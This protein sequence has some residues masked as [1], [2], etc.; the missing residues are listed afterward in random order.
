MRVFI[1]SVEKNKKKKRTDAF[2]FVD[3]FL[4]SPSTMQAKKQDEDQAKLT[5]TKAKAKIALNLEHL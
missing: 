2:F 4:T 3:D 5:H 1:Q